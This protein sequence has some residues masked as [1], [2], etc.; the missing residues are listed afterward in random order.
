MSGG[1]YERGKPQA[2]KDSS[3]NSSSSSSNSSSSSSSNSSSSNSHTPA[4]LRVLSSSSAWPGDRPA[5]LGPSPASR[6]TTIVTVA[7]RVVVAI[8]LWS[9]GG[10]WVSFWW[11]RGKACVSK[12]G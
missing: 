5:W 12:C 3:S 6:M 2:S 7:V 9:L 1:V 10:R 11:S 4:Q 8:S